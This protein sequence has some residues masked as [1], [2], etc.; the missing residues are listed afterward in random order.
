MLFT[1]SDVRTRN[2]GDIRALAEDGSGSVVART[3]RPVALAPVAQPISVAITPTPRSKATGAAGITVN[4][5]KVPETPAAAAPTERPTP[6][7]GAPIQ[8]ATPR[9]VDG[10]LM[11][12]PAM[13]SVL[14]AL[15]RR[16]PNVTVGLLLLAG[17]ALIFWIYGDDE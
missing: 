17:L 6:A 14:P 7:P 8:P 2:L 16:E 11:D 3:T 10:P 13:L 15:E 9:R 1:V 4:A 5:P 12:T